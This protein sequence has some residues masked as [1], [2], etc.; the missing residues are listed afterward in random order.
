MPGPS[1]ISRVL[2]HLAWLRDQLE[3]DVNSRNAYAG[4]LL[5]YNAAAALQWHFVL[6]VSK[7]DEAPDSASR[8]KAAKAID[9]FVWRVRELFIDVKSLTEKQSKGKRGRSIVADLCKAISSVLRRVP[10][11]LGLPKPMPDVW[12]ELLKSLD[13]IAMLKDWLKARGLPVKASAAAL[14]KAGLDGPRSGLRSTLAAASVAAD[15]RV[16]GPSGRAYRDGSSEVVAAIL[17]HAM[18]EYVATLGKTS[19]KRMKGF[20]QDIIGGLEELKQH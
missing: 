10:R 5:T 20:V 1:T 2:D 19:A 3:A 14:K 17:G 15:D 8:S 7:G 4:A 16:Y 9:D 6:P 18:E 12:Y 13:P 11:L